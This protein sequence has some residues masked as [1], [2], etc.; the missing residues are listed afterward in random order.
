VLRLLEGRRVGE[1][2]RLGRR[3]SMADLEMWLQRE[4]SSQGRVAREWELLL[5]T[6]GEEGRR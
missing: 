4:G 3:N 6:L 1:A 5:P 2:R